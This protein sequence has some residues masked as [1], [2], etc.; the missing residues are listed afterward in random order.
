MRVTHTA[1]PHAIPAWSTGV[2]NADGA[3]LRGC[4]RASPPQACGTQPASVADDWRVVF[5]QAF[6]VP[7]V[8]AADAG[9]P[10]PAA[11]VWALL[12]LSQ[13]GFDRYVRFY[14]VNN[15][16]GDVAA[17][18]LLGTGEQPLEP[19]AAGYSLLATLRNVQAPL[20]SLVRPLR[21]HALHVLAERAV[22]MLLRAYVALWR[23]HDVASSHRRQ[24]ARSRCPVWVACVCLRRRGG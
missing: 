13:P 18:A 22:Q 4:A 12:T 10:A 1:H 15:D 20:P 3:P 21:S 16:T 23:C 19:N 7:A 6:S 5:R 9:G 11:R 24:V 14:T 17:H 2:Q 8:G